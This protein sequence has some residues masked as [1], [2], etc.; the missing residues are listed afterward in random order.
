MRKNAFAWAIFCSLWPGI[1]YADVRWSP[2][3]AGFA[4]DF[5]MDAGLIFLL[6]TVALFFFKQATH[7]VS[8]R[9]LRA[10]LL[11]LLLFCM[12]GMAFLYSLPLSVYSEWIVK[13]TE[14]DNCSSHSENIVVLGGGISEAGLPSDQT[15][16]RLASSVDFI[17]KF[18]STRTLQNIYFSG[19]L[20][21]AAATSEAKV[22]S[23]YFKMM[24]QEKEVLPPLVVEEENE[25]KN[26]YQNAIFVKKIMTAKNVSPKITLITS[27]FHLARSVLTFRKAG[28]QV[29]GFAAPH[30]GI[31]TFGILNFGNGQETRKVLNEYFGMLGYL[32]A[33]WI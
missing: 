30:S 6:L 31:V 14:S 33:G 3:I 15:L 17:K 18:H 28:F 23:R 27:Q 25:S 19:G 4:K 24:L 21:S 10:S 2:A 12:R 1:C 7:S 11:L 26:T 13:D 22:M 9:L 32:F 5:L 8:R 20:T 16:L 29:C